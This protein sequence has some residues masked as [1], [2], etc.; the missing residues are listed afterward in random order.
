MALA[1]ELVEDGAG[2]WKNSEVAGCDKGRL[3]RI[4]V[5]GDGSCWGN[6]DC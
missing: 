1:M 5:L 4:E 6:G 2:N 3:L